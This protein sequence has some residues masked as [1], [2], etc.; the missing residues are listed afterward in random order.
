MGPDITTR[1]FVFEKES[2]ELIEASKKIVLETIGSGN[3]EAKTDWSEMELEVRK[4]LRRF[5]N[6][7][8]ERKPVIFP[9]IMEM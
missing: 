5:Y 4:A 2:S 6:K 8:M 1:G 9:I 7:S 3:L